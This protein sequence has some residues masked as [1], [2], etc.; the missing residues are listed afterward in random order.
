MLATRARIGRT[1]RRGGLAAAAALAVAGCADLA[2]VTSLSP[3]PVD[4]NSPVA[5]QVRA[6]SREPGKT[7]RFRDVPPLPTGV[8]P[9]TAFKSAV[10]ETNGAGGA[11]T[12]WVA[13]NPSTLPQDQAETEAFAAGQRARI[14]ADQRGATPD[15]AGSE[16]YAARLRALATPPPPPK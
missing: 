12:S 5:A 8:R 7:P 14:P 11:L 13:A 6:A 9:A 4:A 10:A 16:E 15:P 1:I 3:Q 2:R